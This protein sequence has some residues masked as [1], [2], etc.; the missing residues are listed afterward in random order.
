[1]RKHACT[2]TPELRAKSCL[3]VASVKAEIESFVRVSLPELLR[4]SFGTKEMRGVEIRASNAP[5][6]GRI[7]GRELMEKKCSSSSKRRNDRSG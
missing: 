2:R 5:E 1:M 7:A 4:R 3:N 6:I